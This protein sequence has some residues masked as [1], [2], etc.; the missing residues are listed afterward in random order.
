MARQKSK[1]FWERHVV[2][3]ETS[4]LTR[5]AYCRR[6]GLNYGTMCFW[7]RRLRGG[8]GAAAG[9][10][11]ALVPVMVAT[12]PPRTTTALLEIRVGAQVTVSVP[13]SVDAMWLGALLRAVSAC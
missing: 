4:G 13:T 2:A 5:A 8:K 10:R 9:T 11:Q 3:L 1:G 12:S 7:W 6:H